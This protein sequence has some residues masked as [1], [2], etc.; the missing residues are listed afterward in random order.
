[1]SG[2]KSLD[3]NAAHEF[4]HEWEAWFNEPGATIVRYLTLWKQQSGGGW[5]L[6][7]DISSVAPAEPDQFGAGTTPE[8]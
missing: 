2:L 5:Q 6:I 1:M 7:E 8:T 3:P 4:V